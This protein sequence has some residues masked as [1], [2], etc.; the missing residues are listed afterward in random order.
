M[1][2]C[3]Y[4][5]NEVFLRNI[6]ARGQFQGHGFICQPKLIRSIDH[7]DY[8]F[9]ISDKPVE[10]WVPMIAENYDRQ[11]RMAAKLDD[12]AV[13]VAKI[14]TSTHIYAAAFGCE[15]HRFPD[16][17]ACALPLVGSA[18]EADKIKV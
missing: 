3:K 9:T 14:G 2:N 18:E 16:S 5:K 10:N 13:P 6:Y 17:P 4:K 7:P 15:V 1:P 12:D 8:D 11:I